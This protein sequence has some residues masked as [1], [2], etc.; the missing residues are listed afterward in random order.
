M[1]ETFPTHDSQGIPN[2]R[3]LKAIEFDMAT[4]RANQATPRKDEDPE[5]SYLLPIFLIILGLAVILG[6]L[7]F[8]VASNPG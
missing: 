8:Y 1:T 3:S 4:V 5:P 2:P 6:V 7:A